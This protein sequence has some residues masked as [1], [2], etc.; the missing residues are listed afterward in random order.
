MDAADKLGKVKEI[1]A[2]QDDERGAGFVVA[3]AENFLGSGGTRRP[4]SRD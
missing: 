2:Q 4:E 3:H 1:I